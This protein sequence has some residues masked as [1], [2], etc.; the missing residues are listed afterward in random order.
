MKIILIFS[1]ILGLSFSCK[2]DK[3]KLKAITDAEL[4]TMAAQT[5]G[6]TWY[7]KNDS[8]YAKSGG[9]A[10]AQP[11]LRTRYNGQA[12]THLDAAGKVVEGTSFSEGSLIVKELH[13]AANGSVIDL[14]A[15]L[16]KKA[17]DPN[18]DAKGWVWGYVK[19]DGTVT[20]AASSKGASCIT[21]HSQGGSIDYTLMNAYF[22]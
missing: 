16:L 18:A 19:P 1:L 17:D 21:C 20:S 12:A 9:S 4:L 22:P 2:K 7:Y 6:F 11:F 13:N 5:S 8:I 10:H 3:A 15:I 14:Y